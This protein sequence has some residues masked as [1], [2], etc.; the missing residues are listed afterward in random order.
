MAELPSVRRV[1]REEHRDEVAE[2][3]LERGVGVDVD[4]A[5]RCAVRRRH[6]AYRLQHFVAEVAVRA[7]EQRQ[8]QR[9]IRRC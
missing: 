9:F 8:P 3:R 2:R 7:R 4:D 5:Q 6:R 1:A